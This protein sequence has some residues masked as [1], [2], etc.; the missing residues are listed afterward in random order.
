MQGFREDSPH[1]SQLRVVFRHGSPGHIQEREGPA[2]E[3]RDPSGGGTG[4][5]GR[6]SL[7]KREC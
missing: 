2:P 6:T 4:I 5:V 3:D 1:N 7:I